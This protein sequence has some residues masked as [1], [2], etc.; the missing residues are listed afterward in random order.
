[1]AANYEQFGTEKESKNSSQASGSAE[2]TDVQIDIQTNEA[3]G[4]SQFHNNDRK[5]G[6]EY[7]SDPAGDPFAP[8]YGI[9]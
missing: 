4:S 9:E 5:T 3:A 8:K 1:M 2:I 7:A 6:V